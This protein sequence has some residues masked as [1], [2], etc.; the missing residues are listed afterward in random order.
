[1][2]KENECFIPIKEV[3]LKGSPNKPK[4]ELSKR[5]IKAAAITLYGVTI[6]SKNFQKASNWSRTEKDLKNLE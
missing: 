2:L 6:A 5:S 1:M 3:R 4:E